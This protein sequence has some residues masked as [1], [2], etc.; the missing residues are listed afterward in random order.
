MN[1]SPAPLLAT[2]RPLARAQ[3][4]PQEWGEL[5]WFASAELGNSD[6]VTVGRC[7]IK[8]GCAN[9]L[10]SHP[11]CEEVLVVVQGRIRHT[12]AAGRDAEMG[13]GDTV[14]IPRGFAHRAMNIGD[15]EAV[16]MITFTSATR[17]V[18]GE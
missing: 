4:A 2:V 7:V 17:E 8:P 15:G 1:A 12:V 5:T 10:H 14:T 11:N 6:A 13:A 9:P 3:R 18:V 16:L